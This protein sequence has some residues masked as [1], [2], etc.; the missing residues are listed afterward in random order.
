MAE[1]L[2][3]APPTTTTKPK[4][5]RYRS[6]SF[7]SAPSAPLTDI[8]PSRKQ[9][10]PLK[11]DVSSRVTLGIFP[12]TLPYLEPPRPADDYDNES[13][14]STH[15]L[16]PSS[17]GSLRQNYGI[18]A[19]SIPSPGAITFA[20]F[21]QRD[22]YPR[23]QRIALYEIYSSS[24]QLIS[25]PPKKDRKDSAK[26]DSK[27]QSASHVTA[28]FLKFNNLLKPK[29]KKRPVSSTFHLLSLAIHDSRTTTAC[30]LLEDLSVNVLKKKRP[31][32]T[33][34]CFLHAV[35]NGLESLCL[36]FFD[37]GFPPNINA[38]ALSSGHIIGPPPGSSNLPTP[39]E[40]FVFPS[41][42]MMVVGIGLDNV[43]RAM[44]KRANVNQS[45]YGLT[46][47][48]IAACKGNQSV[49]RSLIE[50]GADITQ[51]LCLET[52]Y[53]FMNLKSEA[54]RIATASV[55]L[56]SYKSQWRPPSTTTS[57]SKNFLPPEFATNRRIYAVELASACRHFESAKYLL[58]KYDSKSIGLL[59]FCFI[60]PHQSLDLSCAYLRAGVLPEM[61]LDPW[62]S[63]ALHLAARNGSL[64]L[65]IAFVTYSKI[66][67]NTKG[68]NGWTALHEAVSRRHKQVALYLVKSGIDVDAVN[69]DNETASQVGRK[70]GISEEDIGDYFF[71]LTPSTQEL[72]LTELVKKYTSAPIE[73]TASQS[74]FKG[75][76]AGTAKRRKGGAVSLTDSSQSIAATIAG[77]GVENSTSSSKLGGKS[78]SWVFG[79]RKL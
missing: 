60:S 25:N 36:I 37:K 69:V 2:Q 53:L 45:W 4:A 27:S 74:D 78:S 49:I 10:P 46:P 39:L 58:S 77:S 19:S 75:S 42:F 6:I 34:Y 5:P 72:E 8:A 13:V 48:H 73:K 79:N 67:I 51:G 59:T 28:A 18:T 17:H 43:I 66:D 65:V 30:Q 11:L 71:K 22:M 56:P 41:Y 38:P 12:G 50:N 47:L 64:G 33:N 57:T 9:T 16:Q 29:K 24:H 31:K 63:N 40:P 44:V 7:P 61:Q 68:Q 55:S 1:R 20:E 23:N 21:K 35:A 14:T 15:S 52:Y 76:A 62:K 70:V 3:S 32:E 26:K 54:A